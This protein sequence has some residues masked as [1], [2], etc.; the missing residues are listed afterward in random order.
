MPWPIR[1]GP[2]PRITTLF[3]PFGFDSQLRLV[4][5]VEIR[6][7]RFELGGAC[8]HALVDRFDLLRQ[9]SIANSAFLLARGQ[10]DL[11]IAESRPLEPTHAVGVEALKPGLGD[12]L[13]QIADLRKLPQEPRIDLRDLVDL[14]DR[15][16]A[17]ERPEQIPHPAVAR[18]RQSFSQ[19]AIVFL[20]HRRGREQADPSA[21]ARAIARPS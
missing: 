12:R 5:A 9:S 20:I 21:P 8:I 6:R 4:R 3:R 19:R 10:R 15:P 17:T 11:G 18:N 2:L 13:P 16:A 1:L 14:L 7:E